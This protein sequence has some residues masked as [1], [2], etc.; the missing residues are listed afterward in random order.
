MTA[1]EFCT[2][3]VD[4]IAV[5]DWVTWAATA[6]AV[7]YV[8]F[9]LRENVWCWSFG[10]LSSALSVL[11]YYNQSLWYES[12]LNILYVV[13]GV[14]GWITW[15]SKKSDSTARPIVRI[16]TGLWISVLLTGAGA[17][18]LMGFLSATYTTNTLPYADAMIA[19]FSIVATWMTA[20]KYLENWVLWIIVDA[21]A[22]GVYIYK[23]P[24]LYLFALLFIFYTMM[25][26]AGYF[27]WKKKI[28]LSNE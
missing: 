2:A 26:I 24:E 15:L 16:S 3:I 20:R 6:T 5:T 1:T 9:A 12:V 10:I 8:L 23:G 13:L 22:A 14:Y 18:A 27:A 21:F 17:G 11:L 19:S 7:L 4:A 25:S 28:T